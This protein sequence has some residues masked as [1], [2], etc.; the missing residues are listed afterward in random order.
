[1]QEHFDSINTQ[2]LS[3]YAL[4]HFALER[5]ANRDFGRRF[6]KRI[7]V[8]LSSGTSGSRGLFVTS[9]CE[10]A[11]WAGAAMARV[12]PKPLWN[13][14]RVALILRA[15][16]PLYE[17]AGNNWIR[18]RFFDLLNGFGPIGPDLEEY[19]PTLL[20]APPSVLRKLAQHYPGIL[21]RLPLDRVCSAAESLSAEDRSYL[22]AE[23]NCPLHVLYQATEGF[24]ASTCPQGAL[25]MHEDI[26]HVEWEPVAGRENCFTPILTDMCRT[27]QPH[28]RYRLNDVLE[29]DPEP[30]PC[31]CSMTRIRAIHGRC[32]E[33]LF[34]PQLTGG[35]ATV[36]PDLLVRALLRAGDLLDEFCV[37]QKPDASLC[38]QMSG[39]DHIKPT[40]LAS[41][42]TLAKQLDAVLPPVEFQEWRPPAPG[43][44]LR[45]VWRLT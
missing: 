17:E 2:G 9:P 32:D 30:C 41:L 35:A 15:N 33:L 43:S 19:E 8:G 18:F 25:H 39:P 1:M 40:I 6:S 22:E 12:L 14:Q 21:K 11:I 37:I 27:T 28:I 34:F 29:L 3:L 10:E 20:V 24:L 44:K 38:I 26:L 13:R 5:E 16:N 42:A 4:L 31:G 7:N 23:M 45:R 36:F